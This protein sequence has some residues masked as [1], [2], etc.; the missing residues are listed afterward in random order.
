MPLSFI[1]S[2]NLNNQFIVI[3]RGQATLIENTETH[4]LSS[5]DKQKN[6]HGHTHTQYAHQRRDAEIGEM[7][8]FIHISTTRKKIKRR[9]S[10]IVNYRYMCVDGE[11]CRCL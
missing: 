9:Y 3:G 6:L 2:Y 4:K 10:Q 1:N 8:E 11:R 5:I 7:E